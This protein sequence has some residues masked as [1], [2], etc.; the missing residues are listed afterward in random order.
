MRLVWRRVNRGPR[1]AAAE[2]RVEAAIALIMPA[3][4]MAARIGPWTFVGWPA[5]M[6]VEFGLAVKA[7]YPNCYLISLANGASAGYLTTAEAERL[8]HYEAMNSL[9]A[10]PESGN[11]LVQATIELLRQASGG[12][13]TAVT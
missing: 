5:E 4:I 10:S 8:R 11:L 9:L 2:G 12:K 7:R 1:P 6:Y 3:E 13:E